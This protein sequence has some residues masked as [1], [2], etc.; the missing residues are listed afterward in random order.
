MKKTIPLRYPRAHE[1]EKKSLDQKIIIIII[2]KT[3]IKGECFTM[4]VHFQ[5]PKK[6]LATECK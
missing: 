3:T 4:F 5:Q 6:D 2:K 1:K